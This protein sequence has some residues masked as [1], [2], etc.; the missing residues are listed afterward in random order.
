MTAYS[1]RQ[2]DGS[3]A[4]RAL[5]S[6]I[7]AQAARMNTAMKWAGAEA[8][9]IELDKLTVLIGLRTPESVLAMERRK[10]LVR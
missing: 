1:A 8:A 5:E 10:G 2:Q 4:D 3:L 9:R 6:K 7:D